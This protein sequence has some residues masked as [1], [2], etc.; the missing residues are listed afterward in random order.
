M[1]TAIERARARSRAYLFFAQALVHPAESAWLP[2]LTESPEVLG[3]WLASS[4]LVVAA[5]RLETLRRSFLAGEERGTLREECVRLFGNLRGAGCSP[6]ET[7]FSNAHV[8]QRAQ[9]MAD[10]AGFYRAF[11]I[12]T[13]AEGERVDHIAME[14]EF[15]HFLACKEMYAA[16]NDP[17][18]VELC[19]EAQG[20]FLADHLGRWTGIFAEVVARTTTEEFYVEV[21]RLLDEFVAQD[22]TFLGVQPE[23]IAAPPPQRREED[24]DERAMCG[25][26]GDFVEVSQIA[27][28]DQAR[29]G[30]KP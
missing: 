2:E 5:S 3:Q 29:R 22:A 27:T 1:D 19:R 4:D 20:K 18:Q 26:S 28:P 9:Q 10:I 16:Q 6:Y 24:E 7:E 8:F 17:G 11:G 25:A 15:M 30:G 21:T 12:Q 13:S 23:R 14:L